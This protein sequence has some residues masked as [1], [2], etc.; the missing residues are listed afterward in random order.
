MFNVDHWDNR[1]SVRRKA[2]AGE[3]WDWLTPRLLAI[4]GRAL[5]D[6]QRGFEELG[7]IL[8]REAEDKPR[9]RKYGK[10]A[11]LGPLSIIDPSLCDAARKILGPDLQV[12]TAPGNRIRTCSRCRPRA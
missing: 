11:E 3:G 12:L 10:W 2:K 4:G 5:M 1:Q 6:G 7:E 8:R 9:E